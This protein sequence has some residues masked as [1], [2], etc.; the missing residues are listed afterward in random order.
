[1][2]WRNAWL[3]Y[4]WESFPLYHNPRCRTFQI[5]VNHNYN[6]CAAMYFNIYKDDYYINSYVDRK[7]G[8]QVPR[9]GRMYVCMEGWVGGWLGGWIVGWMVGIISSAFRINNSPFPFIYGPTRNRICLLTSASIPQRGRLKLVFIVEKINPKWKI[10][11]SNININIQWSSHCR[12]P[13]PK[14]LVYEISADICGGI[15]ALL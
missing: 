15:R 14:C 10:K 9:Y 11:R 1:M 8:M 6:P 5:T 13:F 7:V 3:G 4:Q 12:P 2:I